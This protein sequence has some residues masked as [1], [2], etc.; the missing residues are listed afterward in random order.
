M[1]LSEISNG[2]GEKYEGNGFA[3]EPGWYTLR[4][5]CD[6]SKNM[7]I[8][9]ESYLAHDKSTGE[10]YDAYRL[11]VPFEA[12]AKANGEECGKF[13]VFKTYWDLKQERKDYVAF[14][15]FSGVLDEFIATC[16]DNPDYSSPVCEQF[17]QAKLPFT[18]IKAEVYMETPKPYVDKETG[19]QKQGKDRKAF[20]KIEPVGDTASGVADDCPF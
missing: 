19:E 1:A 20:T 14:L 16:G 7:D 4:P 3:F 2:I 17:M 5:V 15:K 10:E 9:I 13:L 12:V 6:P 18:A 8:R 11:S